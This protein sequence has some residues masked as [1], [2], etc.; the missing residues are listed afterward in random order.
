MSIDNEIIYRCKRGFLELDLLLNRFDKATL[1][2]MTVSDKFELLRLF[3]IDDNALLK[4]LTKNKKC[5]SNDMKSLLKL[6]K[7]Y[8]NH[9]GRKKV[10]NK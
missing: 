5:A 6:I 10:K 2:N 8:S 4:L 7:N 3:E 1:L 9:E